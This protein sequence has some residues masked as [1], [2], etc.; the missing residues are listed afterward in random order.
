MKRVLIVAGGTG[1]HIFPAL[2]LARELVRRE[3][4]VV[5]VGRP[6]GIERDIVAKA[7][8][9]FAPVVASKFS[10]TG[11]GDKLVS[12]V[13]LIQGFF[14]SVKLLT[15]LQPDALVGGG[16]FVSAPV[17]LAALL[18]GRQ[19]FLLEQNRIPGKVTRFFAPYARESF[20]AFPPE[21]PFPGRFTVTGTPL[22]DEIISGERKDDGKTVLILGGSQGARVLNLAALDTAAALSNL[23]FIVLTGKR[24][25]ETIRALVRS[26]NCE[27]VEWTDHP[28]ELY[29]R[30]TIAVS[31]AGGMVT[32]ELLVFGIPMILIPFPGA[33]DRHQDANARYLSSMGAAIVLEQTQISGL[34]SLVR[35]LMADEK[36]RRDME[37]NARAL[38]KPAAAEEIAE[39][40]ERCL[41]D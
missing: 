38:A 5:W 33:A 4:E 35:T 12:L 21:K 11:I 3:I 37:R 17:L 20:L 9:D 14:Q 6:E 7:G 8:Y 32:S 23:N 24:D 1:G 36:R 41:V 10:G 30:A 39:R 31:R 2:A 28:E 25:Y 19:F 16:G 18:Q 22:R 27:L 34:T 29:R 13:R 26:A 15:K 40:I